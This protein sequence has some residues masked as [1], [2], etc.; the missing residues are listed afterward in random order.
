MSDDV[1]CLI[2][3]ACVKQHYGTVHVALRVLGNKAEKHPCVCVG[4]KLL[5]DALLAAEY[6]QQ[7]L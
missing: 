3:V 2:S 1:I 4:S 5:T 7:H 6:S